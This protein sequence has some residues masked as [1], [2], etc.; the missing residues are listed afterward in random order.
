MLSIKDFMEVIGYRITE[1]SEYCWQCYGANAYCLDSWN[2]EHDGHTV[3]IV[4]DTQT[5]VVYQMEVCDYQA[6]R[7]YR[8]I[9]P[10]YVEAHRNEANVRM[11]NHKEAWDEVDFV[12]LEVPEDILEKAR[13]I[14]E[15]QEYDT[16]VQVPLT[17]DK[18]QMYQLMTMAHEQ[19]LTLN[20]LVEKILQE[21]VDRLN[22]VEQ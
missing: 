5:Q 15:G 9:N 20:Q 14:V 8:W 2:G 10:D 16:R 11:V 6:N 19:D 17:L 4:F 7:A 21:E 12:E 18:E 22:S 1:G 3:S 13:A